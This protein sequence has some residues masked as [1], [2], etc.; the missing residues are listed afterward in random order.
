MRENQTKQKEISVSEKFDKNNVER[1]EAALV[2][3]KKQNKLKQKELKKCADE[4]L[5]VG[6]RLSD[7]R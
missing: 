1:Y 5:A 7:L 3:A 2:D 4:A 6:E